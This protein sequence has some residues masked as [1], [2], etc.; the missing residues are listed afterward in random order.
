M[1]EEELY[2]EAL[3]SFSIASKV[4]DLHWFKAIDTKHAAKAWMILAERLVAKA[5]ELNTS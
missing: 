3:K 2:I 5:I 4:E 1:T